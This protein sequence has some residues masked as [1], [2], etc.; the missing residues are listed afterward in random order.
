MLMARLALFA[1]M[2]IGGLPSGT[3]MAMELSGGVEQS[4]TAMPE[5]G[6]VGMD[7]QVPKTG[8][9]LVKHVFLGAPAA[10]AGL[11]SG[12]RIVKINGQLVHGKTAI[13]IDSAISDIPGTPVSITVK[14]NDVLFYT[15]TLVVAPLSRTA[16]HI[17]GQYT[18]VFNPKPY[19]G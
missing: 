4:V 15:V 1:V 5:K 9:P 6:I 17:Q 18:S 3:V 7:I 19:R 14:R 12:D 11:K 13:D 16:N 8:Y 10:V 2:F